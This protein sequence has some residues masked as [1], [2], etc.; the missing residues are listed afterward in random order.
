[1]LTVRMPVM[2]RQAK[3]PFHLLDRLLLPGI[4]QGVN[5]LVNDGFR[6]PG[7]VIA[8]DAIGPG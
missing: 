4:P 3:S 2:G 6:T 1:M 7:P 5:T 8:S